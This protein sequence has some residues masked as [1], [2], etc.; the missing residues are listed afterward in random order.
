MDFYYL[1][2]KANNTT[3][4]AA[5]YYF[6]SVAHNNERQIGA[7]IIQYLMIFVAP[8]MIAAMIY[9]SPGRILRALQAEDCSIFSPRWQTKLFVLSIPSALPRS[10]QVPSCR[11][12][13]TQMRPVRV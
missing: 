10:S 5:G 7:Y 3:V 8:P 11:A 4:E 12:V 9:M 13:K 1:I 2:G 6:R